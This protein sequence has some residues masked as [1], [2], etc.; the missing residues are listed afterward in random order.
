MRT[1]GYQSYTAPVFYARISPRF[2]GNESEGE[3]SRAGGQDP[4]ELAKVREFR[5]HLP[6]VVP[7]GAVPMDL[8]SV[9]AELKGMFG[10]DIEMNVS[11]D[12]KLLIAVN[13][14]IVNGC[15]A[16]TAEESLSLF[17]LGKIGVRHDGNKL[18]VTLEFEAPRSPV[19]LDFPDATARAEQQEARIRL[20]DEISAKIRD[21]LAIRTD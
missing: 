1:I 8:I 6:N 20:E 12:P 11:N 4:E 9:L 17:R 10:I 15:L 7:P 16:L 2:S 13:R 5:E 14:G 21:A 18:S 19:V 3:L